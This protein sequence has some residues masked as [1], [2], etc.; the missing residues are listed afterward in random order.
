MKTLRLAIFAFIAF[1]GC[2]A[3]AGPRARTPLLTT[4]GLS[5]RESAKAPPASLRTGERVVAYPVARYIDPN[6]AGILHEAHTVY[7]VESQPRWNLRPGNSAGYLPTGG[8]AGSSVKAASSSVSRSGSASPER[9]LPSRD[10][11]LVEVQRQKSANAELLKS[12]ESLEKQVNALSS[13]L[14]RSKEQADRRA[15]LE[16]DLESAQF[17]LS[18]LESALSP[19]TPP[20]ASD[21][22]SPTSPGAASRKSPKPAAWDW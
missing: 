13:T 6:H 20:A 3:C 4:R 5:A 16:K 12:H 22:A 10:E 1:L 11:W 19:V 7:R 8:A 2:T 14:S 15:Q 9:T 17:R 21:P 18:R